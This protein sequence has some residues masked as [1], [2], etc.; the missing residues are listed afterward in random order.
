MF[1]HL[2]SSF[3]EEKW[4]SPRRAGSERPTVL[5]VPS[6]GGRLAGLLDQKCLGDSL[7]GSHMSCSLR[8]VAMRSWVSS[9]LDWSRSV[10]CQALVER[11]AASEFSGVTDSLKSREERNFGRVFSP[12]NTGCLISFWLVFWLD[13]PSQAVMVGDLPT[14]SFLPWEVCE[15]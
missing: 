8:H 15:I 6:P 13:F 3:P 1:C 7:Y 2:T 10:P 4:R 14:F 5:Q 11:S 9:L 12:S